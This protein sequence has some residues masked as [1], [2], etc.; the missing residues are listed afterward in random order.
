[1]RGI[2]TKNNL[3]VLLALFV[4]AGCSMTRYIEYRDVQKRDYSW[5]NHV[6]SHN[7]STIYFVN[8]SEAECSFLE[9]KKDS[10]YFVQKD[11]KELQSFH[12]DDIGTV[13]LDDYRASI[14][15][16]LLWGF[17]AL[18]VGTALAELF[19]YNRNGHPNLGSLAVGIA[20]SPI[21][22]IPGYVL[23]GKYEFVFNEIE[24]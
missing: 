11:S 17:G 16:C 7:S 21:G 5:L 2:V 1:M 18:V 9:V 4:S 15:T 14:G 6:T 22:I 13:R 3:I 19:G 10:I 12:L 8:K 20:V 23:G 24:K